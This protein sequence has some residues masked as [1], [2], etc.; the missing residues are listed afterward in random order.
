[1]D[2]HFKF[3]LLNGP[4]SGRELSIPSG[5][6]TVGAEDCDLV[7]PLEGGANARLDVSPQ[8]VLLVSETPCWV[9][10]KPR[11][12]GPLPA[13]VLIDLAGLHFVCGPIDATLSTPA[14]VPRARKRR[15]GWV[16]AAAAIGLA[17]G[18]SWMCYPAARIPAPKPRD[19]LPAALGVEP[20]LTTRWI[21]DQTLVLSGRCED[22]EQ[23]SVIV[24]RLHA[25][26]VRLRQETVCDDELSQSVRALLA[27]YGYSD[28]SVTLNADDHAVIDA[29]VRNDARLTTLA[30]ALDKLPG[31]RGWHLSD[32]RADELAALL[33]RLQAAG[34]L[35]GLSALRSDHG[36]VLSGQ[37]SPDRQTLL[38]RMLAEWNAEPGRKNLLRFIYAAS[39]AQAADYLPATIASVG[40]N[41]QASFLELTNGMRL[42]PGS[43][44]L[45]GMRVL[46]ISAEGISLVNDQQLAFLP[47]HD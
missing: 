34:M 2:A 30:E 5:V 37:L 20:R 25:A 39:A 9:A 3:K 43:P 26:G 36:W 15:V 17:A 47:L 45:R 7:M 33:P 1:M 19:W 35:A 46:A 12:P 42:Q 18:L 8:A 13:N 4:L 6:F 16:I 41:A 38:A 44:V 40:G 21:D 27:D 11:M 10:G 24:A 32:H 14:A 23:L 28:V 31:L 22:R 29:A